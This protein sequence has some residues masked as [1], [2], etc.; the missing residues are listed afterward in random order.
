MK[1]T[2]IT[3]GLASLT[4]P[5]QSLRDPFHCPVFF[6]PAM[7]FNRDVS[8]LAFKHS[9]KRIGVKKAVAVDGLCALGVRG[10]R[11][12][13]EG[14]NVEKMFF[15]DANDDALPFLKKN[16]KANKLERVSSIERTD[17]NRFFLNSETF[18]DFIEIDP[19]GS[20]V[21]FLE[22]AFRRLKKTSV[23][24]VTATDL[25][26]LA[27]ARMLP[28]IKHYDARPLHSAYAHEIALRVLVGRVA[29]TAMKFDFAV[30]PL[31]SFYRRHYVKTF[32]L[33]EKGAMKADDMIPN[34]GFVNHCVHCLHRF[35][36]RRQKECCPSCRE[37]LE[38]AGPLWLSELN[39]SKFLDALLKDVRKDHSKDAKSVE[40]L[41]RLLRSENAFPVSFFDLH[42]LAKK[43]GVSVRSVERVSD[44]LKRKGFQ[45]SRTHFSPTSIKTNA[46]VKEVRAALR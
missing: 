22:S 31:L 7:K 20:P 15:V 9:M 46:S 34:I 21:F 28:C 39:D 26:N 44:Q 32:L 4:I 45:V 42:V 5:R 18:F 16:V 3:E 17:L 11:Y 1:T 38:A 2:Q 13:L 40:K 8:V 14:K 27:G 19:F 24:S 36:S 12:A 35:P 6:N 30:L 41:I 33:C 37:P 43:S 25:A 10:I 23:L 29:R